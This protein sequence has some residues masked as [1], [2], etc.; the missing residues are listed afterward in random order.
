[1]NDKNSKKEITKYDFQKPNTVWISRKRKL[2]EI[3]SENI[4]LNEKKIIEKFGTIENF[5]NQYDEGIITFEMIK[6]GDLWNDYEGDYEFNYFETSDESFYEQGEQHLG[7]K[8]F[9][10]DSSECDKE[11]VK[12]IISRMEEEGERN[13]EELQEFQ[14]KYKIQV[15]D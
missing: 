3:G 13:Q 5:Y 8:I 4:E 9:K 6:T 7:F 15:D 2:I 11:E 1:M 14:N 12:S 10:G